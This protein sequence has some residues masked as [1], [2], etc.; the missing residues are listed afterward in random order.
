MDSLLTQLKDFV[1][2]YTSWS[3]WV[4]TVIIADILYIWSRICLE[5]KELVDMGLTVSTV[6]VVVFV[7]NAVKKPASNPPQDPPKT[8]TTV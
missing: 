1:G 8:E 6:L 3:R 2:G 4:G 7:V 5:K